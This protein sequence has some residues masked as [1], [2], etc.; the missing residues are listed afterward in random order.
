MKYIGA[1]INNKLVL[2]SVVMAHNLDLNCIQFY[3]HNPIDQEEYHDT[4]KQINTM[5]YIRNSNITVFAH[6]S[7]TMN[8]ASPWDKYTWWVNNL[9]NSIKYCYNLYISGIIVHIGKQLKLSKEEAYNNMFTGLIY[10]LN[11]TKEYNRVKLILETPAGQ[12]TELCSNIE[13]LGYFYNKFKLHNKYKDRVKICIDTC[14]LFAAGYNIS[15]EQGIV[16]VFDKIDKNIGFDNLALIHLNDSYQPLNSHIDRHENLGK[17]HIGKNG[18]KI[19]YSF[20]KDKV[21]I[22]IETPKEGM[23]DDILFMKDN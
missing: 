12:G 18:L 2:D 1:H 23:F 6:S 7:F 4:D 17:G 13:E 19:F 3:L 16:N 8:I 15:T 5:N 9:I 20:F 10:V 14:H 11:V 21:P 22:V